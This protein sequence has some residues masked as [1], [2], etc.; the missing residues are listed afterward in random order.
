MYKEFSKIKA[1]AHADYILRLPDTY[2]VADL[3]VEIEAKAKE[4]AL[5]NVGIDCHATPIILT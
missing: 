2:G 3:D 1:P 5:L 4:Q